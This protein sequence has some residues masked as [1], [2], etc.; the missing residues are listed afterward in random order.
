MLSTY[1]TLLVCAVITVFSGGAAGKATTKVYQFSCKGKNGKACVKSFKCPLETRPTSVRAFCNLEKDSYQASVLNQVA[2]G[3]MVA[4]NNTSRP[5]GVCR[6]ADN[7]IAKGQKA[8]EDLMSSR[9][10]KFAFGCRG[11]D[12]RDCV[13]VGQVKCQ[14]YY[15]PLLVMKPDLPYGKV[16]QGLARLDKDHLIYSQDAKKDPKIEALILTITNKQG[17]R[18]KKF[19]TKYH[20]HA[21]SMYIRKNANGSSDI[22]M[23]TANGRGLAQ[24]RLNKSKGQ[25]T[26]LTLLKE[27]FPGQD[28]KSL[29]NIN[30]FAVFKSKIAILHAVTDNKGNKRRTVTVFPLKE[31][32]AGDKRLKTLHTVSMVDAQNLDGKTGPG[33]G[34]ALGAKHVYVLTGAPRAYKANDPTTHNLLYQYSL[35]TGKVT[36][37]HN[38]TVGVSD[39]IKEAKNQWYEPEG[40]YLRSGQLYFTLNTGPSGGHIVRTYRMSEKF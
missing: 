8:I 19:E 12:K 28:G 4:Q 31:F 16:T 35:T 18:I 34:L 39:A 30:S 36:K 20:S 37:K 25:F 13:I 15:G 29:P 5:N 23:A 6:V 14:T 38:I 33:Q 40:L 21:Q 2:V 3:K 11:D 1:K 26:S 7:R 32:L 17:E 24:F 10:S 9:Y 27:I 22:F